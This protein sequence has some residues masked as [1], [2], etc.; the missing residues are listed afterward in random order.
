MSLKIE[1]NQPNGLVTLECEDGENVLLNGP[2]EQV[3]TKHLEDALLFI[4]KILRITNKEQKP[5]EQ[6]TGWEDFKEIMIPKIKFHELACSNEE[7]IKKLNTDSLNEIKTCF[8]K[9][10]KVIDRFTNYLNG[11]K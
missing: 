7:F 10:N 3:N 11:L 5:D 9:T 2:Y 6:F 8:E 4:V 1:F